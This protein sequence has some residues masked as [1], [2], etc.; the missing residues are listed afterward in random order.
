MKTN[1]IRDLATL[2]K[3]VAAALPNER[4]H[5]RDQVA[6]YGTA[7]LDA[8]E[9]WLGDPRLATFA[10]RTIGRIGDTDQRARAMSVLNTAMAADRDL[11]SDVQEILLRW[12]VQVT[13]AGATRR[14]GIGPSTPVV[15]DDGLRDAL[16]DGAR[17]ERTLTYSQVGEP[18]GLT[19]RNPGHRTY[20]GK[21]LDA[22][23]Q[24]EALG[25]RPL[26]SSICVH[27][28]DKVPG[29]GFLRLGEELRLVD[30]GEDAQMFARRQVTAT[31]AYW[32]THA[33]PEVATA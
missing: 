4:M 13:K 6:A 30:P 27:K 1:T 28:G 2:L 3:R 16:I 17:S 20:L 12:G 26:L 10:V 14:T 32:R 5:F 24:H 18:I 9:G 8:M 33:D 19:M 7:G 29:D 23:S 15:L 21:L 11:G 31:F 22:V 25:G